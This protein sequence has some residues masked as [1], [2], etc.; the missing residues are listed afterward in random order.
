MIRAGQ[1]RHKAVLEQGARTVSTRGGVA[2]TWSELMAMRV[3]AEVMSSREVERAGQPHGARMLR[4]R[5]RYLGRVT[6]TDTKYR[7][8]Y[9]DRLFEIVGVE[10]VGERRRET[11]IEAAEIVTVEDT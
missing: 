2:T 5:S 10:D 3:S 11:V 4:F 8:R 6:L 1:L 9:D 7:L